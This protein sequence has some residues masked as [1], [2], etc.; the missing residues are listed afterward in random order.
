[1]LIHLEDFYG[2]AKYAH[3]DQFTVGGGSDKYK[4]MAVEGHTGS[5]SDSFATHEG[6]YFSTPDVDNDF[7]SEENCARKFNSGWWFTR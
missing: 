3:Y 4:L 2:E 5:L 1:M 6:A 7:N